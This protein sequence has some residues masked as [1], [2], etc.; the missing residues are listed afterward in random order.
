LR[1]AARDKQHADHC[2]V[3]TLHGMSTFAM[4]G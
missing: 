2:E 4:T 1:I 3:N